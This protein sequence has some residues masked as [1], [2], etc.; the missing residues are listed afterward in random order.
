[1]IDHVRLGVSDLEQ[2][3]GVSSFRR[4]ISLDEPLL[5]D[6]DGSADWAATPADLWIHAGRR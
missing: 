2:E 5:I 6:V 1:M 4:S 3:R